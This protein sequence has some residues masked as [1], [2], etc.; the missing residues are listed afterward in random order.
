MPLSSNNLFWA[1]FYWNVQNTP[2]LTNHLQGQGCTI[3]IINL[4]FPMLVFQTLFKTKFCY[5]VQI[6]EREGV[7]TLC[8]LQESNFKAWS[9][10]WKG[11]AK[12]ANELY[13]I[14]SALV[15]LAIPATKCKIFDRGEYN[16]PKPALS[17]VPHIAFKVMR[18][19][20]WATG[21]IIS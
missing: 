20:A 15:V 4:E 6:C 21:D 8:Q 11:L 17:F 10:G 19:S 12:P 9:R 3:W 14:K 18:P 7:G 5:N 1:S 2:T 16:K 13:G